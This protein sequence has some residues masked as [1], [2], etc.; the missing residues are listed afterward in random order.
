MP[1]FVQERAPLPD[2]YQGDLTLRRTLDRLL[3]D[4]GH[5]AAQPLLER[6]AT[7]AAGPLAAAARDAERHPPALEQYDGWGA[8]VDRIHTSTGWETL[9]KAAATHG[10]VALPYEPDARATWGSGA[11][12]VQHAMV[13]LY[14]P[15]SATFSCP[16]AMSDGA[17]V[18]LAAPGVDP[19]LRDHLLPRLLAR[20]PDVAWTSG[21]WMTETEGGSDVGRSTTRAHRGDGGWRVT[22]EKWF[23]SSTTS[24]FAL[25]LARP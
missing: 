22:G 18:V 20:D 13:H 21:Q 10:L 3:G 8:R 19:A 15:S 1:R 9:R 25:A 17:A 4:V 24:E 7:D 5:K 23:C 14:A 12:L 2:L 6:L 16:V 11:R